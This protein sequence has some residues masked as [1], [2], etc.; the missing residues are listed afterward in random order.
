MLPASPCKDVLC[1]KIRVSVTKNAI[2]AQLK[3]TLM[4]PREI[5]EMAR[6]L[7]YNGYNTTVIAEQKHQMIPMTTHAVSPRTP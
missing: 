3:F 5:W 7:S 6:R 2:V 1:E 4:T